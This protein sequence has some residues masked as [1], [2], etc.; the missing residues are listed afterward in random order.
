MPY[1]LK[2]IKNNR[3]SYEDV[4][5]TQIEPWI[6]YLFLTSDVSNGYQYSLEIAYNNNLHAETG[7]TT[8]VVKQ[9]GYIYLI[10]AISKVEESKKCIE[11]KMPIDQYVNLIT[12]WGTKIF[13]QDPANR[14]SEVLIRYENDQFFFDI[15]N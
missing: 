6:L 10:D 9:E 12:T 7:N 11:I 8:Y 4:D 5:C 3:G 1:Q 15:K 2:L 13:T 14:P